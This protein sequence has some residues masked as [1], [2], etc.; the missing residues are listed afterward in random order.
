MKLINLSRIDFGG[1]ATGG[2]NAKPEEVFDVQP[3]TSDQTITP[4]EGSVFSGGT[5]RAVTSSID[6]NIASNNI[7]EGVTILGVEGSLKEEKPEEVFDVQ[8][9]TAEQTITPTAGSVFSGGTVHAVTS[10]IDNNIQP[11]N[12]KEGVSILGV[13]GTLSGG[14][15]SVI[16]DGSFDEDGLR[17]IGWT[18][19]DIA[20]FEEIN[21]HFAWQNDQYKVSEENKAL[22]LLDDLKPSS[23]RNNPNITFVPKKNMESYFAKSMG[24]S[25]MKYIKGIPSYDTSNMNSTYLLFSSCAKLTTIPNLDTSNTTDFACMFQNCTNLIT[26]PSLDTSKA[27]RVSSMFKGCTSL[28]TIP[29]LDTSNAT[30]LDTMFSDCT[31]LKIIPRL[32]T[33]KAT[34]LKSM[35]SGCPSLTTVEGIDFSGLTSNLIEFFGTSSIRIPNLTRFIVNGKINVSISDNYSIKKLIAIDYDSVKS[36]LAA[37]DRTDNTNA[38]SLAFNRTMTDQNGE[39]AALVASCTSKGWTISGLTLQ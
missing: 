39:L 4:T 23:Y 34:D 29:S 33:S 16:Y 18:D 38:K 24:F 11:E 9:T 30:D 35:L 13:A 10:A 6:V 37:A 26:I 28:T 7:K 1:V 15:S 19:E 12:I 31:N 21:P 14:G 27:N 5:V 17:A 22:Y 25:G 3:T 2:G 8:P 32:D 20:L 36:I